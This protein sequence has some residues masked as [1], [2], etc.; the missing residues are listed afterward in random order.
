MSIIKYLSIHRAQS[1]LF[2]PELIQYIVKTEVDITVQ[3]KNDGEI[4][5]VV[6]GVLYL[7]GTY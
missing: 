2:A 1:F 7:K 3:E 6:T 4:I 5:L